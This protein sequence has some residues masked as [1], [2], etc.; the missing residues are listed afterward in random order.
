MKSYHGFSADTILRAYRQ[1]KPKYTDPWC[2]VCGRPPK[3]G[4]ALGRRVTED[5]A[6]F[7]A[8]ATGDSR[9]R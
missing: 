5:T 8:A 2:A 1:A 9:D 3:P 4:V 6:Q 7:A